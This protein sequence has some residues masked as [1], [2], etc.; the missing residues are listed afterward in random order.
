MA[1]RQIG[2]YAFNTIRALRRLAADVS[3]S[4]TEI[5]QPRDYASAFVFWRR[6]RKLRAKC[7][8][9]HATAEDFHEWGSLLRLYQA[10]LATG[11]I[12][13]DVRHRASCGIMTKEAHK[14]AAEKNMMTEMPGVPRYSA[15]PQI[16]ALYKRAKRKE[17]A[18]NEAVQKGLSHNKER[19]YVGDAAL[20]G[21]SDAMRSIWRESKLKYYSA[22]R[23]AGSYPSYCIPVTYQDLHGLL[24]Y[25]QNPALRKEYFDKYQKGFHP[26]I[27]EAALELVKA[28]FHLARA[29]GY[30]NYAE[31]ELSSM[32]VRDVATAR[33]FLKQVYG[34]AE[35]YVK[36]FQQKV[37]E[38]AKKNNGNRK[39]ELCDEVFYRHFLIKEMDAWKLAPYFD[40]DRAISKV[41]EVIGNAYQV[42]IKSVQIENFMCG[43]KKDVQVFEVRDISGG[44]DQHKHLGF[45]YLDVYKSKGWLSAFEQD[46]PGAS[47]IAPGHVYVSL[48]S[49]PPSFGATKEFH[50]N[51]VIALAHEFG[52]VLHYLLYPG[53]VYKIFSL[54]MDVIEL[55]STLTENW[56]RSPKILGSIASKKD[57]SLAPESL[58][59]STQ[60]DPW[61]FAE[62]VQLSNVLIRLHDF[63]PTHMTAAQ[64]RQRGVDAW[65]E[66][67][68]NC[69]P[70]D[71]SYN[72]FSEILGVVMSH[73]AN[74]IAYLLC[75]VYTAEIMAQAKGRNLVKAR[76][77]LMGR[78]FLPLQEQLLFAENTAGRGE[79]RGEGD[80]DVKSCP[81]T[82]DNFDEEKAAA[83]IKQI[84]SPPTRPRIN[85]PAHPFKV[86]SSTKALFEKSVRFV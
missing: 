56:V 47:L 46:F 24:P 30:G 17:G 64:L 5:I 8:S 66:F 21:L 12:Q 29:L 41:L 34:N 82:I 83:P 35:P 45:V 86:P 72:L 79:H 27:D 10:L 1:L 28:R 25:C 75:D 23:K 52:H 61:H 69:T 53:D 7:K 54:P 22:G 43:F 50:V 58:L 62:K 6:H 32:S 33:A 40:V 81:L 37:R 63:D 19:L 68:P 85:L 48:Q 74:S 15:K 18:F 26:N 80:E 71:T 59:K 13:S 55:P 20:S 31:Y 3:L 2:G 84:L 38:E 49:V 70:A 42:Q 4:R 14:V 36:K 57:G 77:Q 44:I 67:N 65:N 73:G 51:E 9:D 39:L 11:L 60:H 78:T 16:D 76:S